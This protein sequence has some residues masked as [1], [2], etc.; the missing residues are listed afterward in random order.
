[1]GR[2]LAARRRSRAAC[3]VLLAAGL[4]VMVL[5]AGS[6]SVR[7][8]PAAVAVVGSP[9]VPIPI[10]I[11]IESPPA[12]LGSR[13]VS[14]EDQPAAASL[15]PVQREPS[16]GPPTEPTTSEVAAGVDR[17]PSNVSIEAIE[18]NS[19]VRP[20]GLNSD[21]SLEVPAR[22]PTYDDAGW[23]T[24]SP[25]PGEAGPAILLG[26]VNGRGGVPS[27]FFRLAE[28]REGDLVSVGLADGSGNMFEVYRIEQYPK[29]QF[30][31]ATVYGDTEGPELRLITCAGAWDA[32]TSHYRDNT[33]VYAREVASG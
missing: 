12:D 33:V 16:A 23:F 13:S 17:H 24:G 1:M 26:H 25:S 15:P 30:P 3:W 28:L 4:S 32:E 5:A 27:V 2:H 19:T 8:E 20:L 7:E 14:A 21:G 31:T 29:D 6:S 22:G 11:P 9:P 10:P 18:V